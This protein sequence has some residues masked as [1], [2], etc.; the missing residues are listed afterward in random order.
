MIP[1]T[2]RYDLVSVATL[3]SLPENPYIHLGTTLY[4]TTKHEKLL[5]GRIIYRQFSANIKIISYKIKT[6]GQPGL[7]KLVLILRF[8]FDICKK[9]S[10]YDAI[11]GFSV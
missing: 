5:C 1:I 8:Y 2:V 11:H 3:S 4:K 7:I 10:V 6:F 9:L